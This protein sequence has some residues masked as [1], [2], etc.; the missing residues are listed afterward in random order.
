MERYTWLREKQRIAETR[1]DTLHAA[2]YDQKWGHINPSHR[3]FLQHFL[4]SGSL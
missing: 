3:S 2:S 4:I 1:Y